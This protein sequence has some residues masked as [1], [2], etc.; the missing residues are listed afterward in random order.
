M[1]LPSYFHSHAFKVAFTKGHRKLRQAR[2]VVRALASDDPW[3]LLSLAGIQRTTPIPHRRNETRPMP[4]P[5][6]GSDGEHPVPTFTTAFVTGVL[7]ASPKRKVIEAGD[8][9]GEEDFELGLPVPPSECEPQLQELW[10]R[11]PTA[12]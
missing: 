4:V 10:A 3:A 11:H 6:A 1:Q 8:P 5:L 12:F 2:A 7:R 9:L